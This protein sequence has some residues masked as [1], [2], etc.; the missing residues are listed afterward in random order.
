MRLAQWGWIFKGS[1]SPE[2]PSGL[3]ADR[4]GKG[5]QHDRDP[6]HP[7]TAAALERLR[8]SHSDPVWLFPSPQ[9]I[10]SGEPASSSWMRLKHLE[11]LRAAGID[12]RVVLHQLRHSCA[13]WLRA[14]GKADRAVVQMKLGH[15]DPK[16]TAVYEKVFPTEV[17][18]A[19]NR[20]SFRPRSLPGQEPLF[21]H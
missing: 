1:P 21:N 3:W 13:T 19:M 14:D 8:A 4:T 7:H 16:S 9:Q 18:A 20:V 11:I 15:R 12:E 2:H 5:N 17:A 6:I 10:R